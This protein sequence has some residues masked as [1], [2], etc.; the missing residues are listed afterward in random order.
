[1]SYHI[2]RV[3]VI[4]AGT[5]GA[6]IAAHLANAGVPVTLLDI[7]PDRL[8]P[9]EEKKGLTLEDPAVRNRIVQQGFERALKS[10]PASFFTSEH[11]SLVQ[12]G[13]LEDD[14]DRIAEADWVV[15]VVVENLKVKRQ[16]MERIDS[17]R[18][19]EAIISTN[20]SG[21]PV[22][23]IAEGRSE[24]FRQHFLGTHFFNPPRYLKLLEVIPTDE[25][26]PEVLEVI[27]WFGEYRLGKGIVLAK[28][29]P[30]FIGNRLG[31]GSGAFALHYILENGYTVEEVDAITGP[32][33]GRPKT[34][35]F[36]LIDLVG[37][38]V[39]EHVGSNLA[40]L[41]PHDEQAQRYLNS[42]PANDLIH[43]LVETGRLGNKSKQG[44]YKEVREEGGAKEYWVLDL[45][46][47]EYRPSAKADVP[48]V[49]KV[50][51]V[52]N[53]GE[54]LKTLLSAEGRDA[55]LV[56]ALTYQGFSYASSVI[57]EIADTPIP[58]DD[59]MRWGFG[60]DAG[61]FETWDKLGVAETADCMEQAGYP[62]AAWVKD[63]LSKGIST[64]YQ[65]E[66]T[67]KKAV[68]NAALGDY[69]EIPHSPQMLVLKEQKEAGK[70][71]SKNDGASL[72]DIGDGVALLE[73][74]TKMNA[75]DQDIFNMM[76]EA[77]DR[78]EKDFDGLVVGSDADNFSAGANLFMVVMSAQN[79]MWDMLE[80]AVKGMQDGLM[81]VRYFSK[82]VVAAP[83]GLALGGGAEVICHA[84]RVVAHSEL[85]AGFVE[86]G[87]GVIP[88]GGGTK[89]ML[90]R[91]LNPPM[92]TQNADPL[93]FLQRIFEQIGLA[94]VATSAEEA[95]QY[96][97]LGPSDRVV[98]N[99]SH[100][101]AEAKREVLHMASGG[102]HPPMPEKVY[103][104]GR[105]MLAAMRVGIFMFKEARQITEYE[106]HIAEKLAYV[107]TGGELSKAAWM[108][109]QY[110]LDLERE[111]FLSLCG[112]EKTQQRMWNILQTGKPL[113]N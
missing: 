108:D 110:F 96:E 19:P 93:P 6:G 49:K 69:E 46:T 63:M 66:G 112:E 15:E 80:G 41:I 14:F 107:M 21:I 45:K 87:A 103:A 78:T 7:V 57:P 111:A 28:D 60:H 86:I 83:A 76:N 73:F 84:P 92:R 53:L 98:M 88:A 55:D 33:M 65:Y 77:L 74:H 56:R 113:R 40:P 32:A 50:K 35:T 38:D 104:A 95:R 94:K 37:V 44:F 1:M 9:E 26:L 34:A 18:K 43:S 16:L 30:N 99:R 91:I 25:T 82:P 67:R 12:T 13:N 51:E 102:Y 17:V 79:G 61:P 62:A 20:T 101:L 105:D 52:S 59:A 81:R 5:M 36:R 89:E 39:W 70:E 2:R 54:R 109:E 31:F 27:S 64:F 4:G 75:L 71:I 47:K 48:A 11:A 68:Y 29:T 8:T 85:Y 22:S 10:R 58:L 72:I 42:K 106:A 100:L 90:R 24:S 23:S 3:V 97:I